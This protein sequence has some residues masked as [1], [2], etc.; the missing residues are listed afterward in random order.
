M[1]R[2]QILVPTTPVRQDKF[3]RL[4]DCLSPQLTK[5]VEVL[6]CYNNFERTIGQLREDMVKKVTAEYMN[7]I[8]DDDLVPDNYVET[9]LPLL[10]GVDYVGFRMKMGSEDRIFHTLRNE[11][12]EE[13]GEGYFRR[14]TYLN[15]LKT[16][17]AKQFKNDPTNAEDRSWHDQLSPRTKTEHYIEDI[18]YYYLQG[19]SVWHRTEPEAWKEPIELPK[20]FRYV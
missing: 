1:K 2:W 9:I 6:V 14:V 3:Q 7:F 10:D 18:M 8:D 13:N 19:E 20:G 4:V 16:T 17:I 11:R 5:D 12:W 15:P